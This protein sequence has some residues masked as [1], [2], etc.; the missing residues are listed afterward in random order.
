MRKIKKSMEEREINVIKNISFLLLCYSSSFS[1]AVLL[2]SFAD[3]P[4][5]INKHKEELLAEQGGGNTKENL[6]NNEKSKQ[7]WIRTLIYVFDE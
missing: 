5:K 1:F 4:V 3:T 6:R 7:K 2:N